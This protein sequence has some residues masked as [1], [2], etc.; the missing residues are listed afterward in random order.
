MKMATPADLVNQAKKMAAYQ[1]VDEHVKV[2]ELDYFSG[3]VFSA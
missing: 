2:C 3:L 1:A